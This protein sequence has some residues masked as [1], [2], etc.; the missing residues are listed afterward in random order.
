MFLDDRPGC[1]G[2]DGLRCPDGRSATARP[3]WHGS[4]GV[5]ARGLCAGARG[6]DVWWWKTIGKWWFNGG[7]MVV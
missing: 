3:E 1:P 7:L 4:G 2:W 6:A 5:V